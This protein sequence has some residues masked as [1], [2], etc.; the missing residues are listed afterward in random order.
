MINGEKKRE[1]GYQGVISLQR[2]RCCRK[3]TNVNVH[4]FQLAIFSVVCINGA[5]C[6][7]ETDQVIYGTQHYFST[8]LT[9]GQDGHLPAI[10]QQCCLP[11]E[12]LTAGTRNICCQK[13]DI[14]RRNMARAKRDT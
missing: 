7:M 8:R 6:R 4:S 1:D 9:E 10:W 3:G 2:K 12:Q 14:L 11:V 5:I 13:L